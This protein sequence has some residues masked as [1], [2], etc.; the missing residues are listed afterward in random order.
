MLL[1]H[2]GEYACECA[3]ESKYLTFSQNSHT[4]RV[5]VSNGNKF[6]TFASHSPPAYENRPIRKRLVTFGECCEWCHSPSIFVSLRKPLVTLVRHS[7]ALATFVR[8]L[9]GVCNVRRF[10]FLAN[11]LPLLQMI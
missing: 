6:G 3:Y 2:M 11:V 8:H 4:Y 9:Q 1:S 10:P 5:I 7:E